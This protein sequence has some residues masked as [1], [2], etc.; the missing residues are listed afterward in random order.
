MGTS[1]N[2]VTAEYQQGRAEIY[3]RARV[4]NTGREVARSCRVYLAELTEIRTSGQIS[5]SLYD[6]KQLQWAG[7][8]FIPL[9]I[10]RG[11]NLYVDLAWVS[12]DQPGWRFSVQRLFAS[13]SGLKTYR[14]TYRFHLL[15]TAHNAD[16][17][18]CSVDVSYDGD[19]H[20]L[21]AWEVKSAPNDS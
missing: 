14:G 10:P 3:I 1:A 19:W 15:A 21:R 17:A 9:D 4:R 5:T 20:S 18:V 7:L 2:Q 8:D 13:Q 6:A 12:K 16:P 11:V